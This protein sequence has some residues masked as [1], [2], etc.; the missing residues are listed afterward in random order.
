MLR[1]GTINRN[2][3]TEPKE[4]EPKPKEPEPKKSVPYSVPSF[5][6]PK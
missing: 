4:P 2:R 3:G 1:V 5:E 6:E